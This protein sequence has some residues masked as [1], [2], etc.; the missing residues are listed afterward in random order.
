MIKNFLKIFLVLILFACEGNQKESKELK[1][2]EK[3]NKDKKVEEKQSKAIDKIKDRLK[4]INSKKE[5]THVYV[6]NPTGLKYRKSP[7]GKILGTFP[8][9]TELEIVENTKIF[10]QAVENNQT[11][12]GEWLGV[13][14]KQDTVYVLNSLLSDSYNFSKME[15]YTATQYDEKDNGEISTGFLNASNVYFSNKKDIEEVLPKEVLKD[16]VRLNIEQR[17][18]FLNIINVSESDNVFIY[19]VN[20]EK[21]HTLKVSSL[22]VIACINAFFDENHYEKTEKQYQFGFDLGD[23]LK[24]NCHI[25][26]ATIGKQNP[27]VVG[28]LNPFVW[29]RLN[30][31]RFRGQLDIYEVPT[32]FNYEVRFVLSYVLNGLQYYLINKENLLVIDREKKEIIYNH[33]FYSGVNANLTLPILE[34][35][36]EFFHR[37]WTGKLF[38]N[39]PPVVFGFQNWVF[40]CEEIRFLNTSDLPVKVL[41]DSRN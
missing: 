19:D 34:N 4:E 2:L 12:K 17:K 28:K 16:T 24:Y 22:P 32:E 38:K 30:P 23:V 37:Q 41:C 33:T 5:N 10:G 6:S 39:M 13:K 8:L 36:K 40:G 26:F 29:K 14:Q 18:K 1:S 27:F 21:V 3:E 25:N 35:E 7:Q 15:V 20:N 9:N 11:L 31:D